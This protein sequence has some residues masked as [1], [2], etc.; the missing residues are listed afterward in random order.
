MHICS[1]ILTKV[2]TRVQLI[3]CNGLL[4]TPRTDTHTGVPSLQ[5]RVDLH[6]AWFY[7]CPSCI[8]Y[9]LHQFPHTQ[10]CFTLTLY[11]LSSFCVGKPDILGGIPHDTYG[12]TTRSVHRYVVNCLDKLGM[13]ESQV[14]V[15]NDCIFVISTF[16]I[17]CKRNIRIYSV[18]I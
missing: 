12:M 16:Y 11:F 3:W 17:Q 18:D 1:P 5:V 10:H 14:N 7:I 13:E 4:S 15:Q 9:F 8:H 2:L 6:E